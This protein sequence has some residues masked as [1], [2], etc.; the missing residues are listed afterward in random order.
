MKIVFWHNYLMFH[1]S[2]YIR[3]LSKIP[4]LNVYWAVSE[5][6][7][8]IYKQ[9]GYPVPN[10]GNTTIIEAP[11]D[12]QIESLLKPEPGE[13][14]IH[15]FFG[16]RKMPLQEK[17]FHS[18]LKYDVDRYIMSENRFESGWRIIPRWLAYS[19]DSLRFGKKINGL[20]CIGHTGSRGGYR[21]FKMT[22]FDGNKI[23]PFIHT[24]EPEQ[25]S[26]QQS[27]HEITELIYVGQM[28][29]RKAVD[30]L[31]KA[32]SSTKDT[33]WHLTLVGTGPLL[34]DLKNLAHTLGISDRTTFSGTLDNATVT[35][36]IACSDILILPSHFDGWGAVVNEAILLGVPVICSDRCGASD[37]VYGSGAGYVF[38]TDDINDLETGIRQTIAK[39]I[40]P[41]TRTRLKAWSEKISGKVLAEYFLE[42]VS[43][44]TAAKMKP[45]APWLSE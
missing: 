42:V 12:A 19:L 18:S 29:H 34:Q 11:S 6:L 26:T 8:P 5:L 44:K 36:K 28:I 1:Q 23:Y 4:G 13:Q 24:T 27:R 15:V 39:D 21:W 37:I 40:N 17:A 10:T 9:R 38:K 43:Q 31:L 45:D 32:L 3:E 41:D 35:E 22:G 25:T 14:S 33:P 30:V 2:P 7:P 16:I 20:F